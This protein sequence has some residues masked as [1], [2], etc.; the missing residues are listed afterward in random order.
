M[1]LGQLILIISMSLTGLLSCSSPLDKPLTP[2]HAR[3][4]VCVTRGDWACVD[5]V[6]HDQTPRC[7]YDGQV[8]WFCSADCRTD[9]VN[10]P[11]R[12]TGEDR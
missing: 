7:E 6:M 12:F 11:Q 2:G 9:F 5:V 3:C 1:K 4:S 8:W 10:A